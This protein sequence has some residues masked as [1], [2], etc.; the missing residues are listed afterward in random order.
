MNK[1][2]EASIETIATKISDALLQVCHYIVTA[3]KKAN[4]HTN[5]S[6][7]CLQITWIYKIHS[8]L[9]PY[10]FCQN[11]CTNI[12]KLDHM[13]F[14]SPEQYSS[15]TQSALKSKRFATTVLNKSR[16]R[17]LAIFDLIITYRI[18]ITRIIH[19]ILNA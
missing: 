1:N 9:Q 2:E 14:I 8:V 11:A 18:E 6:H 13:W 7:A 16:V 19:R 3:L 17:C 12:S 5:N 15:Q 10:I 4:I